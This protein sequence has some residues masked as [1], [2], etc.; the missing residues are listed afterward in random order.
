M[1]RTP[2]WNST[3]GLS[4]AA[5]TAMH[6]AGC[7]VGPDY[8]RPAVDSPSSFRDGPAEPPAAS[9]ADLP[10]W[11]V[12]DDPALQT[13]VREA[14]VN[15][16]EL[17]IAVTRI[18]QAAAIEAQTASPLYPQL[19]YNAALSN[20]RNAFVGS[21]SPNGGDTSSSALATLNAF[22]EIDLW[23]RIR[24]A[25]EAA[26][27]QILA[28][29]ETRRGVMLTLVTA[30]ARAY[31]ELL[32]LDLE[33]V[34]AQENVKSFQQSLDLFS[35][36][37]SG[38]VESKLQ[39]FRAQANLSQVAATIP[40]LQRLI[41]IKEN[42]INLLLGRNPGPVARG[43]VFLEQKFPFEI[44]AGIPSALLE[45]RPDIRVAEQ[46]LVSANAQIGVATAGY[47]P[48]IGLTAF[49]GKVSPE[50]S[51]FS[52][53]TSNA[54][55]V[56]ASI[57]GPIFT[58]GR[59]KGEVD[60]A[61][62][63]AEEARLRYRQVVTAAFGEVANALVSRE[64]FAGVEVQLREQVTSLEAAVKMSRERYDIGR[65]SYFE[66][67]DAQQQLFPAQISLARTKLNE[68]VTIV[69][70]YASL[71][72]GWNLPTEQ[73]ND[74]TPPSAQPPAPPPAHGHPVGS[75]QG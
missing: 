10:W 40:E 56:A 75:P 71:G 70:L 11:Q 17:R 5:L 22:W 21:P 31:F 32:D 45:R 4:A 46:N 24:R 20:G 58:G 15:N 28:A 14:L 30:V 66:I 6:L 26:L 1:R 9:L 64:K 50:L 74:D 69:Q 35:R 27:A 52:S 39:V 36:R 57:A 19:S 42:E 47:Y 23:G 51:A 12:F 16:Y 59:T 37:S 49:M 65:A 38:G 54:W 7:K 68:Y 48:R 34:I 60:Q 3:L 41:A 53:G 29:E 55:S 73:W 2:A 13:L 72:G 8:Q 33:I 67:L 61:V 63:A 62:A 43:N 25:D 18:E 44:P